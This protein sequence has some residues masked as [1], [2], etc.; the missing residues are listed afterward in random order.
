MCFPPMNSF[1]EGETTVLSHDGRSIITY[2]PI[3]EKVLETIKLTINDRGFWDGDYRNWNEIVAVCNLESLLIMGVSFEER[4]NVTRN[5]FTF[6]IGLD[7]IVSY[8]D[9]QMIIDGKGQCK[10]GEDIWDMFRLMNT[11]NRFKLQSKFTKYKKFSSYCRKIIQESKFS[12]DDM[13]DGAGIRAVAYRYAVENNLKQHQR[14]KS[15][16]IADRNENYTWGDNSDPKMMVWH[17]S[18]VV[19]AISRFGELEDVDKSLKEIYEATRT[20]A[21]ANDYFL[22]TYYLCYAAL[23]FI[24]ARR[25]ET[26]MFKEMLNSITSEINSNEDGADRGGSSMTAE[27]FAALLNSFN[28]CDAGIINM[29]LR[30]KEL[31]KSQNENVELKHEI[32]KLNK[33]IK[34]QSDYYF[35][36]KKKFKVIQWIVL[37]VIAAI[38]T[39]VITVIIERNMEGDQSNAIKS[40]QVGQVLEY[41]VS[42]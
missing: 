39:A 41:E 34:G 36:S 7:D 40:G 27:V 6:T 42:R 17:T 12:A 22:K 9:D 10:F 35:I 38:I 24:Y 18:Q 20:P 33:K 30:A 8:L 31:E 5:N 3:C 2:Y 13:W 28:P 29:M 1:Y 11:I 14:I 21:F 4:W 37:T 26:D 23:A 32:T 25:T 19:I 15:S 16:L